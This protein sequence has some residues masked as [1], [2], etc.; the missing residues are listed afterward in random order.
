MLKKIYDFKNF[1]GLKEHK[2]SKV[3]M[4]LEPG[5]KGQPEKIVAIFNRSDLD[6]ME[7][8]LRPYY[9]EK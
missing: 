9:K 3:Q 6:F 5:K 4:L 7:T 8:A 1:K 2:F